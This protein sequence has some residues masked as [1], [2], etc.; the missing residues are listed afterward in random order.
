MLLFVSLKISIQYFRVLSK[1]V[2]QPL[3]RQSKANLSSNL[4]DIYFHLK[5]IFLSSESFILKTDLLEIEL[6]NSSN[7]TAFS[8]P[9][10][11]L[12][13]MK[14]IKGEGDDPVHWYGGNSSNPTILLLNHRKVQQYSK[15]CINSIQPNST[16]KIQLIG[17]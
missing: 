7:K 2:K 10:G 6:L 9:T 4:I 3:R 8:M 13:S 15:E 14:S 11:E 16:E 1:E 5:A 17:S 12:S